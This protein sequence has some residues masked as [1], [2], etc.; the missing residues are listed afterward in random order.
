[1]MFFHR[2]DELADKKNSL[3]CIGIDPQ[4]G[5]D[6]ENA[7]SSLV[8]FG[9]M[10]VEETE[11]Y[12]LCYK[13]NIAFFEKY[14][15]GGFKALKEIIEIIPDSIPVII[16]AKRGDIGNTAKA[17]AES[18]FQYFHAD[19]VTLNPYLGRESF[20]PFLEFKEKGL[21][22]LCRTSNPGAGD[23]QGLRVWNTKGMERYYIQLAREVA[24][25][26]TRIGLVVGANLPL[27][28][29]EIR[30]MLSYV[31][32]LAPGI[33]VQ[34]GKVRESL[35]AG[36]RRDGKGILVS[37]SRSIS[38]AKSPRKAAESIWEE[39]N[40][41]RKDSAS[42]KIVVRYSFKEMKE[43][44]KNELIRQLIENG[45]FQKGEFVLKS[46][47]TSPFYLDLR[48]IISSP[49]L[50][51]D[52]ASAFCTLVRGLSFDRLAGI[53]YA[54]IPIATAVSLLMEKPLI[55]PRLTVKDHGTGKR[56]EGAYKKGERV[57]LIDDLITTGGSKLEAAGILK[58][59]GLIVEDLVVL[60]ERGE[61]A[62]EELEKK[63]INLHSY[64]KIRDFFEACLELG[65]ISQKE[66]NNME[67]YIEES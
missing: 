10:L 36:L 40:R 47:K 65:K 3:L 35:E 9:K 34:G 37:A 2:L 11:D 26:S 6:K 23:I 55:F 27:V 4:E 63:K 24:S 49:S 48:M 39:I 28:L 31:W 51:A 12:A 41:Y 54:G 17:Y 21:F 20:E 57:L 8:G 32:F 46:G 1:M 18:L 14:G 19:A 62:K 30:R 7:L 13:P 45:C 5:I 16:D 38:G 43:Q 58:S 52:V 25:W 59:E 67:K 15:T 53:P 44:R 33:G 42:K 29:S 61:T 22:A 66:K 50:L 60:V 64:L 56:I